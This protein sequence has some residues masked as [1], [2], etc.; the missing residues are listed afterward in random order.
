M[1]RKEKAPGS[2]WLRGT[3]SKH[4]CASITH[5]LNPII[6][7]GSWDYAAGSRAIPIPAHSMPD[8]PN[9]ASHLR[10]NTLSSRWARV[11]GTAAHPPQTPSQAPLRP[12]SGAIPR[13]VSTA[14]RHR[15]LRL[16]STEQRPAANGAG[17]GL[18]I[19]LANARCH[20][21]GAAVRPCGAA[22]ASAYPK[23]GNEFLHIPGAARNRLPPSRHQYDQL[24]SSI[25][26]GGRRTVDI[27]HGAYA[28]LTFTGWLR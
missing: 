22:S 7:V 28:R 6:D 17:G 24:C 18:T 5:K 27:E 26:L 19:G 3:R 16:W 21:C 25:G 2:Q 12:L 23:Y 4:N 8:Q 10:A 15:Q 11:A 9:W 1:M 20:I 13:K 14:V